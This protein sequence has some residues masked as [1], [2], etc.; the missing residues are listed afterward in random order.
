MTTFKNKMTEIKILKRLN[1][2]CSNKELHNLISQGFDTRTS[3]KPFPVYRDINGRIYDSQIQPKIHKARM[4]PDYQPEID[5]SANKLRSSSVSQSDMVEA[6][7]HEEN[8]RID[9]MSYLSLQRLNS[10]NCLEK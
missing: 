8:G 2:R 6:R 10:V 9:N 4:N 3:K 7:S 1:Q 5:L